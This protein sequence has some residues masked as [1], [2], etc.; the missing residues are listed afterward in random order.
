MTWR[1]CLRNYDGGSVGELRGYFG[2]PLLLPDDEGYEAA[3]AG[4]ERRHRPAAP[5]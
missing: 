4:V 3:R 5:P 1:L 2:G